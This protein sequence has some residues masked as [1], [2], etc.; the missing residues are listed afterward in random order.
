MDTH[1]LC[2]DRWVSKGYLHFAHTTILVG[3]SSC[4]SSKL[5]V[6]LREGI[7]FDQHNVID[8]E[9]SLWFQPFLP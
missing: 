9:V 3:I 8:V 6:V 1:P 5:P 4:N 2:V 7:I